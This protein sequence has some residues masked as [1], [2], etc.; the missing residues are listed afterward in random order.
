MIITTRANSVL[1]VKGAGRVERTV[2]IRRS[3][4]R[5]DSLHS[6]VSYSRYIYA[7]CSSTGE[8]LLWPMRDAYKYR[9]LP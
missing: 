3:S 5:K 6:L 2:T 9:T 4:E 8:V 7:L 1:D